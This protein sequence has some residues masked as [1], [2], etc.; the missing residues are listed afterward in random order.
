MGVIWL[1]EVNCLGNEMSIDQCK[2]NE[3][4]EH[5]CVHSEDAGVN[6]SKYLYSF[7]QNLFASEFHN[8]TKFTI[9]YNL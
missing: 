2:K 9:Y 6:C 8:R 5:N 1:D 3:W 4:G 7:I